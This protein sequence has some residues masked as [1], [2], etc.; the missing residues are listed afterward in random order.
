MIYNLYIQHIMR[1]KQMC[2][3]LIT[4][5]ETKDALI[6]SIVYIANI[7]VHVY[8]DVWCTHDYFEMTLYV[9]C[10]H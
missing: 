5:M 6:T 9:W 2:I 10:E 8:D 1:V 4:T 7:K 3:L